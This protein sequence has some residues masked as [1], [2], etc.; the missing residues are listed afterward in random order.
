MSIDCNILE[1]DAFVCN[2]PES[3]RAFNIPLGCE[4]K[5]RELAMEVLS[6]AGGGGRESIVQELLLKWIVNIHI[7]I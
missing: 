5:E 2:E 4:G 6:V 3:F 1:I 7:K